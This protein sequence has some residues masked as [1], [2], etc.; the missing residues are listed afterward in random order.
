MGAID[1]PD[2]DERVEE[3][4][5]ERLL[6]NVGEVAELLLIRRLTVTL[7]ETAASHP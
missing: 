4:V 1:A 2:I 5:P 3:H 6:L 7:H